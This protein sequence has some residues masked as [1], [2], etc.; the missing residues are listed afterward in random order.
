MRSLKE[1]EL[2]G[3]KVLIRVDFNI[4]MDKDNEIIDDT[5]MRAAL[6]T[7]DY[8]L[9]KGA[10]LILLSHL[11]RPKGKPEAKYSLQKVALRLAEIIGPRVSMASDCLGP[12][13]LKKVE[14]LKPGEVLVLENVRFHP[15][16][17]KNDPEFSR[18]L[19]SL[20]DLFVNDAFGSA[21][22]A[23][24][25]TAGIADYLP[26]Y[27][28]FLMEKEVEMLE[29][30]LEHPVSPRMAI[31]GGAKVSDKL[32]LIENLLSK[33]DIILIGGGMAN[34]FLKALGKEIGK[35]I[36]ENELLEQ[37]RQLVEKA[38]QKK[39]QLI[40]PEDVV[41]AEEISADATAK[42]V[43]AE[44]VPD[45]MMILDIGPRTIE[46]FVAAIAQ[47]RTI[48]WNGPLGV[49][50]Y[51]SFAR[52]TEEITKAI[53]SSSAVSVIG[54]GD[55]AVVAYNLGLEA[56]ITHISTGGGATLEFLEGIRL[57]GVKACEE[58]RPSSALPGAGS[59]Q[60]ASL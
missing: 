25:S 3:K 59:H 33:M 27:A 32:G 36:C 53:A 38:A 6:P 35:S 24:S 55:S 14:E 39:V 26:C 43:N 60:E 20:G 15:G 1:A 46:K 48:I 37:A 12:D 28:G 56:Q 9:D 8:I 51:P 16:E 57:P 40:L 7:I 42:N 47:A 31:L 34:T 11:G 22:R 52:G 4:P 41:V 45:N 58:S 44:E 30:V 10:S 2:K 13:T 49:Y 19:A 50:E 5:K 18:Q 29:R 23:H 17:E 54:G 21:H